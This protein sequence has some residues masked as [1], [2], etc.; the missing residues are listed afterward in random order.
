MALV[1]G[2]QRGGPD[3][4]AA[5][6]DLH[7]VR[8]KSLCRLPF[9]QAL[10]RAVVPL[11]EP[12][13]ATDRYP[14]PAHLGQREVSGLDGAHQDRCV[15]DGWRKAGSL[16]QPSCIFSLGDPKLAQ[17]HVV[18]ACEEVCEVPRALPMPEQ[19]ESS[20]LPSDGR[21]PPPSPPRSWRIP[22]R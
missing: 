4:I 17:W 7:V 6:P 12:P 5:P 15:D 20:D 14:G 18:P 10:Q 1:V 2:L 21:K 11:V 8:A 13:A 19:D 9:V 16:H 3:V 22:P